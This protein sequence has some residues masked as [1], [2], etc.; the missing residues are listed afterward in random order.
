LAEY[1]FI[2]KRI[3]SS[4]PE[5]GVYK[6]ELYPKEKNVEKIEKILKIK[7]QTIKK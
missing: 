4:Y 5:I 3:K 7:I 2:K 6:S 1:K